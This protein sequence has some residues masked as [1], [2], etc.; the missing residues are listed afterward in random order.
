M[1]ETQRIP[2]A[3]WLADYPDTEIDFLP[4][5]KEY[6]DS[7]NSKKALV[8]LMGIF[9]AVVCC[10][11]SSYRGGRVVI[12]NRSKNSGKEDPRPT[13]S[14]IDWMAEQG[15]IKCISGFWS[16][17]NPSLNRTSGYQGTAVLAALFAGAKTGS[18]NYQPPEYL[19]ELRNAEGKVIKG[20]KTAINPRA[21]AVAQVNSFIGK[22]RIEIDGQRVKGINYHRVFN[23]TWSLGGRFY[24]PAQTSKKAERAMITIDGELTVERDFAALHIKVAY[25]LVGAEMPPGDAYT[26]E[27]YDRNAIK[28]TAL[29]TL[30]GGTVA[31][32]RKKLLDE[33][34]TTWAKRSGELLDAFIT[35][36]EAISDLMGEDNIGLRLQNL[37]S[38]IAERVLL[39]MTARD[40]VAL[41]W[42]D[43]FI[44]RASR[45][46][47]LVEVMQNAYRDVTGKEPPV[48][49]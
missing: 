4:L 23:Q 11:L 24:H 18:R 20:F 22:A 35:K 27:G 13:N 46:D 29:V 43:S 8:H 44:V 38:A 25:D 32:I 45:S 28:L 26:I 40:A 12:Y 9:R 37:D 39:E 16:Q 34:M 33:G 48:I 19:I 47:E 31:G 36:H 5:T 17:D 10:G 7:T 41:G 30:N 49:R 2:D 14:V 3:F 21:K 42:H 6:K 1:T 15:M